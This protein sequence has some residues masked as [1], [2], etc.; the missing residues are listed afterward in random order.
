MQTE[1][2]I[3]TCLA[4]KDRPVEMPVH[5]DS[6]G[7]ASPWR[8]SH[9]WDFPDHGHPIVSLQASLW[10][11]TSPTLLH[12][13]LGCLVEGFVYKICLYYHFALT[14][15]LLLI[16]FIHVICNMYQPCEQALPVSLQWGLLLSGDSM[17]YHTLVFWQ[18]VQG[19]PTYT[20]DLHLRHRD[21]K[22]TI[23]KGLREACT[24]Y[25]ALERVYS[26]DST[27]IHWYTSHANWM[28]AGTEQAFHTLQ[29]SLTA[30]VNIRGQAHE[31]CTELVDWALFSCSKEVH[32]CS[33]SQRP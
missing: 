24:P 19:S 3:S 17:G 5:T 32:L 31:A 25:S 6:E 12:L 1:L 28:H 18:K 8:P 4:A 30:S 7:Q 22:V 27:L 2:K 14:S 13:K 26:K 16:T 11:I 10:Q 23:M 29:V 33:D 20:W 9:F 21:E 15:R